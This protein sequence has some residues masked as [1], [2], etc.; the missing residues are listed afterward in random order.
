MLACGLLRRRLGGR[1]TEESRRKDQARSEQVKDQLQV[2]WITP[3]GS[4][5]SRRSAG[6][7]VAGIGVFAV[8]SAMFVTPFHPLRENSIRFLPS[9]TYPESITF[10][11]T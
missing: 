5:T 8:A 1:F 3:T 7:V 11:M 9:S 4:L 2:L 6:S 10:G